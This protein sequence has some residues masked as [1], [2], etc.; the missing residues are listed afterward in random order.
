MEY[1]K[2]KL[3]DELDKGYKLDDSTIV[4]EAEA[5]SIT[6]MEW[7]SISDE[8]RKIMDPFNFPEWAMFDISIPMHIFLKKYN[9]ADYKCLERY[10]K[11]NNKKRLN[12]LNE[13][14]VTLRDYL[15]FVRDRK[16]IELMGIIP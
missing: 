11:L 15:Y 10:S 4:I 13:N 7:D 12:I 8:Y 9:I 3:F 5:I 14:C 6:W 2:Y 1:F 16:L